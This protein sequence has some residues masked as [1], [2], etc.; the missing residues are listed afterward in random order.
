MSANI[1]WEPVERPRESLYTLAPQL[2]RESL[3]A[4]GL[5]CPGV[6]SSAAQD[7]LRGMAKVHGGK[8]DENPYLQLVMALERHDEIELTMEY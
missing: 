4:A 1:Y 2:F 3:E 6:I 7:K 5:C 8:P